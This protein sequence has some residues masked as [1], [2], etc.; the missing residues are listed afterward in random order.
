MQAADGNRRKA[1]GTGVATA[2][3]IAAGL[4]VEMY[5]YVIRKCDLPTHM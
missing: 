1:I 4:Q 2:F 5:M 3:G